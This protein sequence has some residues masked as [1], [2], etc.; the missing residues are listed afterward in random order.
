MTN[1]FIKRILIVGLLILSAGIFG[2]GCS[3][4]TNKLYLYSMPGVDYDWGEVGGR[5]NESYT[6]TQTESI[7][8]APYLLN[9]SF[10]FK[11][12]VEGKVTLKSIE[13]TDAEGS[14]T[15]YLKDE[16]WVEKIKAS[17][18]GLTYSAFL[19]RGLVP[20]YVRLRLRLKYKIDTDQFVKEDETDLFFETE[21][22][23]YKSNKFWDMLMSA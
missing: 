9:I 11:S 21:Y 2:S 10:D 19:I 12:K 1:Y 17:G 23:E 14:K 18:D 15:Y 8:S 22:K 4:I 5:M 16:P 20:D 6:A 13:L 3:N 7:A